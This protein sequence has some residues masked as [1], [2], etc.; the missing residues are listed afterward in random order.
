MT[1][2]SQP[3]LLCNP[4]HIHSKAVISVYLMAFLFPVDSSFFVLYLTPLPMNHPLSISVSKIFVAPVV[5]KSGW[6]LPKV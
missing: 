6:N 5:H 3:K 4:F 2:P 1:S